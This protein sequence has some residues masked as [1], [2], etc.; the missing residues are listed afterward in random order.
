MKASELNILSINVRGINNCVKRKSIFNMAKKTNA[1]IAFLQE[2]YSSLEKENQWKN[3]WG[4]DII[5]AHGSKHSRGTAILLK[6]NWDY[7]IEDYITDPAGRIILLKMIIEEER[8]CIINVYAPNDDN[9]QIAY[10]KSLRNMLIKE[11]VLDTYQLIMAGDFN[12]TMDVKMDKKGG[13]PVTKTRP[14]NIIENIIEQFDLIDIWRLKNPDKKRYTWRQQTPPISCRLDYFLISN[15]LQDNAHGVDILPAI[16]S[17]HSPISLHLRKNNEVCR[18]RGYW[19]F[20]SSLLEDKHFNTEFLK[21]LNTWKHD[22]E[23]LDPQQKWEWIKFKT[24]EFC[25]KESKRIT[26]EKKDKMQTLSDECK[27]LEETLDKEQNQLLYETY[28]EKKEELNRLIDEKTEG[29]IMRAKVRWYEEGEKS[30]KYFLNMEKRNYMK[31]TMTRLVVGDKIIEKPDLIIKE[32]K[33]FYENLYSCKTKEDDDT[34]I[35]KQFLNSPTLPRLNQTESKYCD[36]ELTTSQC[37]KALKSMTNNKSPGNDGI[38][39]EFYKHFWPQVGQMLVDSFNHGY[40]HGSMSNSQKQAVITLLEK[41]GKDRSYIKNWRPI[42]LLNIDYKIATKTIA[43]RVKEVLPSIIHQDQTGFVKGRNITESVRTLLDTISYMDL[44][45]QSGL[46]LFLDLEKA[47]DTLDKNFMFKALKDFNFGNSFLKW[48]KTFYHEA[49]SCIM[50]NGVSSGYFLVNRGVRQGDP[51]SAY[52]FIIA[53]EILSHSIRED[54][55]IKGIYI[56]DQ[57]TKLV[58]H[59]DDTTSL[60]KNKDSVNKLLNK[61]KLFTKISGLKLN[62]IKTELMWLGTLKD[63]REKI[64]EVEPKK[65][66][67]VL[68]IT[69]G[70]NEQEIISANLEQKLKEISTTFNLWKMRN[71]TISGRILLAKVYG[72]S[73]INYIASLFQIPKTYVKRIEKIL[74]DFIWKGKNDKVKRKLLVKEYSEGGQ[75]MIDIE[76]MIEKYNIKWIQQFLAP[77]PSNW[78]HIFEYYLKPFGGANLLILCNYNMKELE[79]KLPLFYL[80]ILGSWKKFR[81]YFQEDYSN[82]FLWNNEDIMINGKTVFEKNCLDCGM[83]YYSDL[84]DENSKIIPFQCW[85]DRGLDRKYF[86]LWRALAEITNRKKLNLTNNVERKPSLFF[87]LQKKS[88]PDHLTKILPKSIY[89]FLLSKT[90]IV[91]PARWI[92]MENALGDIDWNKI[93]LIPIKACRTPKL[94]ELQYKIINNYLNTNK[95]LKIYGIK[96]SGLCDI[97]NENIESIIHIFW[98]CPRVK[99]IWLQFNEWWIDITG[100][101]VNEINQ[102]TILLGSEEDFDHNLLYNHLILIIKYYIFRNKDNNPSFTA[103]KVS[104]NSVKTTEEF[105]ARKNG[106]IE[107]FLKKWEPIM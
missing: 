44:K 98:E 42:S 88:K 18:G 37:F 29:S 24:R 19:K 32:Q 40:R 60:L 64:G 56:N 87:R 6:K 51:L 4:G 57:E 49:S 102:R 66:V 65:T 10:Y 76:T 95:Q 41:K 106:R 7:E 23:N 33:K 35:E 85:I 63:S 84:Y 94:R 75:R 103:A 100:T 28:L 3:E 96:E 47:F 26:K 12:L 70:H 81:S 39:S 52:L 82:E 17:D 2:T 61:I 9:S 46:M 50:S 74:F 55:E 89:T 13:L 11:K 53:L 68:G 14:R 107:D 97:C 77:N 15:T 58:Q 90:D 27:N 36:G 79:R 69:M 30:T 48:V 5:F 86:L 78:K 80:R 101:N 1:H 105:I 45:K 43:N 104:V 31:K 54:K 20:N 8:F 71:L 73:K 93:H 22:T 16:K 21:E 25:M 62:E 91:K 83:W 99:T 59:A 72:L 92:K 38:T 67:K 34:N